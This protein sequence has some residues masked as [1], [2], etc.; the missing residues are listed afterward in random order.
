VC[1]KWGNR[2]DSCNKALLN[3]E[4]QLSQIITNH[5]PNDNRTLKLNHYKTNVFNAL[6]SLPLTDIYME[7]TA[8]KGTSPGEKQTETAALVHCQHVFTFAS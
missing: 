3:S 8:T 6:I 2:L 7:R 1:D 5:S 4:R